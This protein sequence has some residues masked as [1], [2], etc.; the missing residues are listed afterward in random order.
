MTRRLVNGGTVSTPSR[1]ATAIL[2]G[3]ATALLSAAPAGAGLQDEGSSPS[4]SAASSAVETTTTRPDAHPV[5]WG[6]APAA[7]P[8]FDFTL[9]PGDTVTDEL[10]VTNHGDVPLDLAVYAADAFTSPTGALDVLPTGTPS[11]DLGAWITADVPR[12]VV[13]PGGRG[14][15][16]FTL[17]VPADATPGDHT[18]AI[19]TSLVTGAGEGGVA[20]DRRLGTRV[21][22]RV[23]GDLAPSATVTEV[24]ADYAGSW[25]PVGTGDAELTFTVTN[26]GNVRLAGPLSATVAGPAGVGS[27]VVPLGDL[28]ELLPGDPLTL[29]GTVS[30]VAP[31]GRLSASVTLAPVVATTASTTLPDGAASPSLDLATGQGH[32]WAVP[33]SAFA[34]AT[35]LVG[36]VLGLRAL[37]RRARV[38]FEAAVDAALAAR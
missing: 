30:G 27:V 28:P 2:V 36:A 17:T 26:T 38:R 6:V 4:T 9:D 22:V 14:T 16:P 25:N 31:L 24:D 18:A 7:A 15:V 8:T 21:L 11:E 3:A 13:D 1:V 37:R 20:V 5:T 32:L 12:V 35:L 23:A 34:L 10:V 33:W 29:T 19:V